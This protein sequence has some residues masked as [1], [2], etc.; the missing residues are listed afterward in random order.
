MSTKATTK[1]GE[2]FFSGA[3]GGVISGAR[4]V[5]AGTT[6]GGALGAGTTG[7]AGAAGT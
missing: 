5:G 3:G 4:T 6:G 1:T 7:V 2:L